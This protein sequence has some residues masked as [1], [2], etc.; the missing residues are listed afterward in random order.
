[1]VAP[2]L[3]IAVNTSPAAGDCPLILRV[4]WISVV[5]ALPNV[6]FPVIVW[7]VLVVKTVD[8]VLFQG[9]FKAHAI[10]PTPSPL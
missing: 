8:G 4:P 9:L 10:P 6:L 2:V 7:F 5:V 1:M 3:S